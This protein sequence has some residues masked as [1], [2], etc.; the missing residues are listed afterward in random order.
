MV[1]NT[2][3]PWAAG[4]LMERLNVGLDPHPTF[5]RD[6][7]FIVRKKLT[8]GVHA[9]TVLGR[10]SDPDAILSRGRRSLFIVPWND[11]TLVGVWHVVYE[12][13]PEAFT[14]TEQELEGYIEE[15]NEAYPA[16]KL[17]LGDV[18]RWMAGLTLFGEKQEG[19]NLRYG[20]RSQL[21]DHAEKHGIEGLVTLLGV[22]ATVARGMSE[23]ALDLVFKKMGKEP[24]KSQTAFKPIYGGE[25]GNFDQFLSQATLQRP[26]SVPVDAMPALVHNHGTAYQEVLNYVR[27]DPCWAESLGD[28][29][30]LKAEVAHAVHSEMAYKLS[31]VVFRRTDL[32]SG[33]HPGENALSEAASIMAIELGWSPTRRQAEV[34]EVRRAYLR[35]E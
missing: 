30:T 2:A 10:T 19:E 9:L 4:L 17:S 22:R 26:P 32:G 8:D 21:I 27:Q 12:G 24:P 5:S 16:A 31:D 13:R 28:S 14:V 11:V 34:D 35:Q 6:T 23:K 1:L 15:I 29:K 7:C 3:G 20:H 25:I 18:C 33:G